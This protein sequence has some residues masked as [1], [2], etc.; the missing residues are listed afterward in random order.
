M[1]LSHQFY[2]AETGPSD[3]DIAVSTGKELGGA[4]GDVAQAKHRDGSL[5]LQRESRCPIGGT[6]ARQRGHPAERL[7]D[8][9]DLGHFL[10]T[11]QDR[12]AY[13]E[14]NAAGDPARASAE[15]RVEQQHIRTLRVLLQI[16][17]EW[18][19]SVA[20]RL[21]SATRSSSVTS[22]PG[23]LSSRGF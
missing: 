9:L 3:R 15:A 12:L 7:G 5:F 22:L 11:R 23:P 8:G 19:M 6:G 10:T 17:R 1:F 14:R 18:I 4:P 16:V 2:W 21:M 20:R 13:D